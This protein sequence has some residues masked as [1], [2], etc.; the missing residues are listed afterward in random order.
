MMLCILALASFSLAAAVS[1]RRQGL[2]QPSSAASGH[3]GWGRCHYEGDWAPTADLQFIHIPRT[4]GTSIEACD[5]SFPKNWTGSRWTPEHKKVLQV[6]G[7]WAGRM[8]G[9][10]ESLPR[11][12]KDLT[13][14]EKT[15]CFTQH[16]PPASLAVEEPGNTVFKYGQDSNFCFVRH[17]YDRLVS[18][19]G[20]GMSMFREKWGWHFKCNVSDLNTYLLDRLQQVDEG[21]R[22]ATGGGDGPIT[23]KLPNFED[24]HFLP[25]SFFTH[26]FDARTWKVNRTE[27]WC[28]HV[29]HYENA[30][31]DFN[32]LMD[33]KGYALRIGSGLKRRSA[34]MAG[35]EECRDLSSK[36][37]SPEVRRLAD[38]IFAEDF[39]LFGYKKY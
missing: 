18:Q 34:D 38:K 10:H 35:K 22:N 17:P 27:R 23:T 2:A 1:L 6:S 19:F 16:V 14:F 28:D 21:I 13:K 32:N 33:K 5:R 29:L 4:M 31:E 24:C 3:S 7:K 37:L 30:S 25:M 11:L 15:R 36:D 12:F 9:R 26:G 8:K 39:E 20:Y